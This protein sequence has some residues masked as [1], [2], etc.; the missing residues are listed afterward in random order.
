MDYK[1]GCCALIASTALTT[2]I[3]STP[4]ASAAT[5]TRWHATQLKAASNTKSAFAH[6]KI[7]VTLTLRSGRV[8]LGGERRHFQV[9]T[10]NELPGTRWSGWRWV[11]AKPGLHR[12]QYVVAVTMPTLPKDAVV[13]QYEF[14]FVVDRTHH[15]RT[16]NA[17]LIN[18]H[19]R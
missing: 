11:A 7:R 19:V 4:T 10:C 14:R 15:Y 2:G 8:A 16:S 13:E 3:A 5:V 9:R 18:V 12:G 1:L 6:Q 17:A